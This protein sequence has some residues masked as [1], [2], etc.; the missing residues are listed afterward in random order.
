MDQA[1]LRE[2]EA[3]CTQEALPL[4]RAHCPLRL[5]VRGFMERMAEGAVT[6]ARKVL[7]R[8]LPLPEI[9]CR[10]C[11]HP[12]EDACLRRDLGGALS[13]QMLEAYCVDTVP[14]QGKI[15]PRTAK[16]A[17]IAVL[18]A[19]L[20]GLTVAFELS[21]KAWPVT[22]FYAGGSEGEAL[23][24]R[25][26]LL[27]KEAWDKEFQGLVKAR[28]VFVGRGLR[29]LGPELLEEA[30]ADFSAVF[31]DADAAAG[32]F[33]G[34]PALPH[35]AT[36]L[37]GGTVCAGGLLSQSP[38]GAVYASA[39]AQAGQGR[40]AAVTLERMVTGVSLTAEREGECGCESR[41][42]TDVTGITP[43]QAVLAQGAVF[44]QQEAKSEAGRCIRCQCLAC[45]RQCVYLQKHGSY[46]RSY[47]RQMYN[48]ASIVK[49]EH[50]ANRLITGCML[51]GQCTELCPERFSMAELCLDSRRDMVRRNYMPPSAHEFALEDMHSANGPDCALALPHAG[52][53]GQKYVFF[54]GCQ[55]AA[56]RGEQVL[57]VYAHLREIFAAEDAGG[58]VGLFLSCC[59]VPAH[60][61]GRE[62]LFEESLA[63]LRGQWEA[64]GSPVLITACAS[65]TKILREMAGDIP[66]LSL[67]QVLDEH[68]CGEEGEVL[69]GTYSV[70][71]PCAARHDVAWQGAVR[72]LAGK[73][74]VTLHEPA[75]SGLHTP[76]CGYGGLTWCAHPDLA[77][78]ATRHV[79]EELEHTGLASC[80]MCRDRL[81][82]QGKPCLHVL[83][84]LPPTRRLAP[85][86]DTPPPGLSARRAARARLRA[87]A[88]ALY[89]G[90]QEA[91]PAA[92]PVLVAPDLLT[93]LECRHILLQ[94]VQAAVLAVEHSGRHF[95]EEDSGHRVG[96]WRPRNVTYWVRYSVQGGQYEV[97]DAWCHRMRVPGSGG[98]VVEV[99][100]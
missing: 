9:L 10:I 55:L 6:E 45:V 77:D 98:E 28:C 100:S 2:I 17:H 81:V 63:A 41:L 79:A 15:L 57:A 37:V 47:A 75:H 52:G 40:R 53:G 7:E 66:V 99:I 35:A 36:G 1:Q 64:L 46:P 34:L 86:K 92:C 31:V 93:A 20:A 78:A 69:A 38:T 62:R 26:P 74:G 83:D 12:C 44:T 18:G 5:D 50:Q 49:G 89:A 14:Q 32:I 21:R 91:T 80:I 68:G 59:G 71:D 85:A 70:H 87:K 25:Y 72:S 58:G 94:D 27:Q 84:I 23:L 61:A 13:V 24:K 65:C 42:H 3:R 54:P 82:S 95:V 97:H 11:D 90:Q 51:C 39:S 4:C 76:C 29:E 33:A 67:W 56:S 22:V 60:W 8:H 43:V 88:L 19:G 73:S 48:N 30:R 16:P 96:S